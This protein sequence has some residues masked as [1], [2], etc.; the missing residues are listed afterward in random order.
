M[1][2]SGS[3]YVT[4]LHLFP[5]GEKQ[6]FCHT[7]FVQKMARKLSKTD[8]SDLLQKLVGWLPLDKRPF[9]TVF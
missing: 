8:Y 7:I 2:S 6:A 5:A 4:W 9:E 3:N 1:F